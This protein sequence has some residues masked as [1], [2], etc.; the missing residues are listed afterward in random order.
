MK[1][2]AH[3]L[4]TAQ[5][6]HWPVVPLMV[7][8]AILT[9]TA[10]AIAESQHAGRWVTNYGKLSLYGSG[11]ELLTG[12]YFHQGDPAQI[13]A[14][15]KHNHVYEGVWIQ[16][17]SE[18]SCKEQARGSAHW[19]RVRILFTGYKFFA[20]WNYCDRALVREPNRLWEGILK[21]RFK[22]DSEEIIADKNRP[23]RLKTHQIFE[24]LVS[25]SDRTE[26]DI[27]RDLKSKIIQ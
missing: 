20:I 23:P 27:L 12:N 4:Y 13:Y 8:A 21:A 7:M 9:T 11:N 17:T 18:I 10:P 24:K 5:P 15:Q 19:G 3:L 6:R 2:F 14:S 16:K 1:D 26:R 25:N 22:G